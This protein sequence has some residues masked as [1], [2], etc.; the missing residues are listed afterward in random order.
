MNEVEQYYCKVEE[1]IHL[2]A[3]NNCYRVVQGFISTT[4]YCVL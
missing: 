4:S 3:I 1:V 2:D